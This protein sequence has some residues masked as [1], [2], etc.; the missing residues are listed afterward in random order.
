[1]HG[2]R[3][4]DFI[5]DDEQRGL[6]CLE[7]AGGSTAKREDAFLQQ[8]GTREYLELDREEKSLFFTRNI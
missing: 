8:L 1:V 4:V 5:L 2:A 7:E 3:E 6:S